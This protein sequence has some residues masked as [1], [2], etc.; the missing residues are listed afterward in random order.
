MIISIMD[1]VSNHGNYM[2]WSDPSQRV[3]TASARMDVDF[4]V[5][6][7]EFL[8][9]K[10]DGRPMPKHLLVVEDSAPDNKNANRQ[11]MMA[12]LVKHDIFESI[13]LLYLLVGHTHWKVDQIF[14]VLSK[15]VKRLDRGLMHFDDLEGILRDTYTDWTSVRENVIREIRN[16]PNLNEFF[17]N[18]REEFGIRKPDLIQK[19]HRLQFVKENGKVVMYQSHSGFSREEFTYL[20]E[21]PGNPLGY[22]GRLGFRRYQSADAFQD[23]GLKELYRKVW[24][25]IGLEFSRFDWESE[26]DLP[27]LRDLEV[28]ELTECSIQ[29]WLPFDVEA[30][31]AGVKSY[32]WWVPPGIPKGVC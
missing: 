25:S 11:T 16:I 7:N 20:Y 28:H 23:E 6:L 14:S 30:F 1:V 26:N 4:R 2:F 22:F 27:T 24:E 5:L 21:T 17:E 10:K 29:T 13:Q 19:Y 8:A 3:H 9:R 12:L 32:V 18:V 15:A 31:V